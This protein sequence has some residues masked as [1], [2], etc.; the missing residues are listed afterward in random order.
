[1]E[2]LDDIGSMSVAVTKL[3]HKSLQKYSKKINSKAKPKMKRPN[4][5][6]NS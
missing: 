1:M 5:K 4:S 3:D 2:D 6:K